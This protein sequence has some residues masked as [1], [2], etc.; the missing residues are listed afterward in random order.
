MT[1][2]TLEQFDVM[3]EQALAAVESGGYWDDY[4][5][6]GAAAGVLFGAGGCISCKIMLILMLPPVL[7]SGSKVLSHWY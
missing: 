4:P 6:V 3:D 5:L 1:T 7:I 2:K